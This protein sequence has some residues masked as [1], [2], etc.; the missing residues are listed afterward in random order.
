MME[1]VNY[2]VIAHDDAETL[3]SAVGEGVTLVT[4]DGH[5]SVRRWVTGGGEYVSADGKGLRGGAHYSLVAEG[6]VEVVDFYSLPETE[7]A[8]SHVR[9]GER[10]HVF[11]IGNSPGNAEDIE[12]I[13]RCGQQLFGIIRKEVEGVVHAALIDL[14][15]EAPGVTPG[16]W[17]RIERPH[18][19]AAYVLN[20]DLSPAYRYQSIYDS[21]YNIVGSR[22]SLWVQRPELFRQPA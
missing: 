19:D 4:P 1:L 14:T 18:I 13:R 3:A 5:M 2:I 12:P 21:V 20:A 7:F 15:R 8:T 6:N 17:A 9:R 16:R 10:N 11:R 22:R